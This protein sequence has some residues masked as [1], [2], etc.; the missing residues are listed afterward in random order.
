MKFS[1][2]SIF[3]KQKTYTP[4]SRHADRDWTILIIFS[5]LAVLLHTVFALYLYYTPIEDSVE[6]PTL[7]TSDAATQSKLQT[8][9]VISYYEDHLAH[10]NDQKPDASDIPDP[11]L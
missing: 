8:D 10:L 3:K 4:P 1:L 9:A 7:L 5:T 2:S 6:R 11:A